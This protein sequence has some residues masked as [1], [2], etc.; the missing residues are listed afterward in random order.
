MSMKAVRH[1][2]KAINQLMQ[3]KYPTLYHWWHNHT[4]R[5][6]L[7]F[8]NIQQ[9]QATYFLKWLEEIINRQDYTCPHCNKQLYKAHSKSPRPQFVCYHCNYHFNA[10]SATRFKRMHR[11]DLWIPYAKALCIGY[12]NSDIEKLINLPNKMTK[13]WRPVFIQQMQDLKLNELVQW[14][15]WQRKRRYAQITKL[16]QRFNGFLYD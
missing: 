5:T 16:Q 15:I 6:D 13:Q 7:S 10:I 2:F 4:E 11:I 3:E 12:S 9:Q 8:A 1:R 14:L